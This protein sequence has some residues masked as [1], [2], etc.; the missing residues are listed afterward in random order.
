MIRLDWLHSRITHGGA[1]EV[2]RSDSVEEL[3]A[4]E[5]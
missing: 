1:V 3:L 4:Q 2:L 5:C